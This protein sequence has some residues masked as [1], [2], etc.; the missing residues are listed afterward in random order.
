MEPHS[1]ATTRTRASAPADVV[2]PVYEIPHDTG[3]CAVVGGYVYRGAKIPE[4]DGTYFFSDNC[5]GTIRTARRPT[6]TA[7]AMPATPA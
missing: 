3:A 2:A 6:A 1:R 5:D 4:L 7:F